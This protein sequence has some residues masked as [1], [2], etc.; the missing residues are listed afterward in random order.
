MRKR[1]RKTM[2][3]TMMKK[4]KKRTMMRKQ[5]RK[6]KRKL[7][8]VRPSLENIHSPTCEIGKFFSDIWAAKCR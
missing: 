3:K 8:L 7:S 1:M 6:Q 5:K 2:K 4:T